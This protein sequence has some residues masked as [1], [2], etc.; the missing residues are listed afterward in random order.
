MALAAL[1]ATGT[2][3]K[4]NGP[5]SA[6]SPVEPPAVGNSDIEAW[7][8]TADRSALL[9][10]LSVPLRFGSGG[11]LPTVIE[12]DT[13]R[14]FQTIDGFGYT[15]TGGSAMLINRQLTAA[16]R[17]AL[18]REL[19]LTDSVGIGIS[20]LRL[21]IGASDLSD[22]VFSYNDLPAG[23]TDPQLQ[24]FSLAPD[25][26]DLIPVLK[27]ILRLN[28]DI[29]LMGSPWSAPVWMKTNG[30]SVG[31]SLK[32]EFY[33][34]YADYFVRYLQEMAKEGIA[35]DAIT[36]QNEPENPHNNP[37]MLMTAAEQTDFIKNFLGPAFRAAGLKTK[38]VVFDHNCDNP[39][40][41]ISILNDA[42]AR[43]FVDGSAFHLYAGTI[44]ALLQVHEAHPDKNLYFTEQWTSSE[45]NFGEDLKWNVRN[46]MIGSTRNWSRIVLQWNLAADP[47]Q[48]PHT[49]GG[50][51]KCLGAL[52]I[53]GGITRNVA[54]YT[55]AH[56]ARFVRPGSVRVFS[57]DIP[58]LPNVA[59]QTP[60]GK[61]VLIVLNEGN[62]LRS[63]TLRFNGKTAALSLAANS[64]ATFVF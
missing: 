47:G 12:I 54:Y 40:Y 14:R 45:G 34:A 16:Q 28:P 19:F 61:K 29:K 53:G 5:T 25:Q 60:T 23:Q 2:A 64:V 6:P 1:L 27:E 59:F 57:T 51:D 31:G 35:I 18:L 11:Q 32:K 48:N 9:S 50:C 58:D 43:T 8:T 22:R 46:L 63:F 10:K 13:A 21:S 37:S 38:I 42:A 56:A 41:P 4:R 52:T 17:N 49:P 33:G 24:Q 3:C 7:V 44:S 26:T 55:I 20:Y 62:S 39:G 30:S 15:L 36:P